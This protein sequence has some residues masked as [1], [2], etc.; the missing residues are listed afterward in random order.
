[1]AWEDYETL[2]LTREE[3]TEEELKRLQ[4]KYGV[5]PSNKEEIFKN[6]KEGKRTRKI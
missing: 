2:D 6:L 5:E 1:M 3:V 4:K